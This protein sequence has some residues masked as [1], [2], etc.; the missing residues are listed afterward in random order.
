MMSTDIRPNYVARHFTKYVSTSG[1]C[2]ELYFRKLS[3]DP[4]SDNSTVSVIVSSE[5]NVEQVVA[6]SNGT[7]TV[8]WR[9]LHAV[10][11]AG[12]FKVYIEG[13][14]SPSGFS[15]LSVDDIAVQ[16]CSIFGEW[17]YYWAT[18]TRNCSENSVTV[19]RDYHQSPNHEFEACQFETMAARWCCGRRHTYFKFTGHHLEFY[20][21]GRS[22]VATNACSVT[23]S[24]KL[25]N[26][27]PD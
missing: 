14:R 17:V 2:I 26:V 20:I 5:E 10:L 12:I 3:S 21:S 24:L 23:R 8:M 9:R 7:E 11:P 22:T 15:S 13:R 6:S 4:N 27:E 16:P 18:I 25:S 1:M 19:I